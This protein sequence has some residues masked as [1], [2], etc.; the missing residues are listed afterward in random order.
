MKRLSLASAVTLIILSFRSVAMTAEFDPQARAAAI[1]PYLDEQTI[2]VA[3]V[4]VSGVEFDP[5]VEFL[6]GFVT[7]PEPFRDQLPQVKQRIT[8]LKAAFK[9]AGAERFY[10]VLSL[11]DIPRGEPYV[12]VPVAEGCNPRA[13]AGLL[14]SGKADGPTSRQRARQANHKGPQ[15]FDVCEIVGSSVVAG[16]KRTVA[17][18]QQQFQR[19]QRK[20]RPEL[21]AAFE[22]A[23]DQAAQLVVLLSEDHRRVISE[24]LP[25]L[26]QEV[27]GISG[28][29]F[30]RG[31]RWA[32]VGIDAPPNASAH[33]V[34]HAQDKASAKAVQRLIGGGLKF[35]AKMPAVQ[36]RVQNADDIV[37]LLTPKIE[38][39]R[40][41]LSLTKEN[42][43]MQ[44]LVGLLK[45]AL[46]AARQ[47]TSHRLSRNNLKQFGLA[48]HNFHDAY[49]SFPPTASY[50]DNG[51]KL[52]SWRVFLLPFL[53][54]GKIYQQF[55][56]DEPWDS[57]HNRKLIP[58]MPA[59]Y[60][61]PFAESGGKGKTSYLA[62]VGKEGKQ[63][64]TV[65]SGKAGVPIREVT[66][67]TSNTI[68]I[69]EVAP[70]FAVP[71][72]KPQDLQI[73]FKNPL[74]GIFGKKTEHTRALFCDGSVHTLPKDINLKTLRVIFTRKAG[75]SSGAP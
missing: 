10:V 27:G 50:D 30:V 39:N 68:M 22:A 19:S 67:G 54:Q 33:M 66:D 59:I 63:F 55:H 65:F 24:M 35:L 32:A 40:L 36:T 73:D 26:P 28:K 1:L 62:L 12:V 70:E 18:I 29:E 14:F 64:L 41:K 38:G 71:W 16:R 34:I 17:R 74:K 52:L 48:M 43:G 7:L 31:F 58:K 75:D 25:Q 37:T 21:A 4:D 49:G 45:P 23:G 60:R 44:M 3:Y 5:M 6:S 15:K 72:T 51:K 56:L 9:N 47:D 8:A 20:A 69:I 42:Q 53:G 61:N 13:V 57:E 2:A 11:A 46:T